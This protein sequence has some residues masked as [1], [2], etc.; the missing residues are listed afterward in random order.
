MQDRVSRSSTGV[1]PERPASARVSTS[2]YFGHDHDLDDEEGELQGEDDEQGYEEQYD[3]PAI[4]KRVS[5]RQTTPADSARRS[6]C[7]FF[8]ENIAGAGFLGTMFRPEL[9]K[10]ESSFCCAVGIG[11]TVPGCEGMP[12]LI[13]APDC[14]ICATLCEAASTSLRMSCSVFLLTEQGAAHGGGQRDG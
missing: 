1:P 6:L 11:C 10:H 4:T 7:I 14:Q 2:N 3:R 13:L 8:L 9:R 12:W 5:S